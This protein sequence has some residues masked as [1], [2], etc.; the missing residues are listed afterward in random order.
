MFHGSEEHFEHNLAVSQAYQW[1]IFT[2]V[3][4][5]N[6][7]LTHRNIFSLYSSVDPYNAQRNDEM[8]KIYRHEF[9]Q[10]SMT[11]Q[12]QEEFLV[13]ANS[14]TDLDWW[15]HLTSTTS[16]IHSCWVNESIVVFI[17]GNSSLKNESFVIIFSPCVLLIPNVVFFLLWNMKGDHRQ[18]VWAAFHARRIWELPSSEDYQ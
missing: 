2:S 6:L 3:F 14:D 12:K 5:A 7:V 13:K 4:Q 17:K 18:N 16:V 15:T 1:G 8:T 10:V 11:W 9:P